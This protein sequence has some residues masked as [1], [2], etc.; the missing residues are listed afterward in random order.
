MS[1]R[2]RNKLVIINK[3]SRKFAETIFFRVYEI[4]NNYEELN[5]RYVNLLLTDDGSIRDFNKKYLGRDT[6]TDVISFSSDLVF[7][8]FLG[9][10]IIDTAV[11]EEQKGKNTLEEEL[12]YLFMHGLLHLLGYDH[13]S[14]EAGKV[15]KSKEEK[16]FLILKENL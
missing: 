13:I 7:T 11:A 1:T 6:L 4:I 8:A 14:T 5:N 15:M 9:D 16:Y 3:T 10:I 12:Q 2:K